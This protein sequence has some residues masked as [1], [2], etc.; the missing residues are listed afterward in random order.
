MAQLLLNIHLRS[1]SRGSSPERRWQLSISSSR[2]AALRARLLL[3]IRK[4]TESSTN[5]KS[6]RRYNFAR[7]AAVP[8]QRIVTGR[9]YDA[10]FNPH[11]FMSAAGCQV[12]PVRDRIVPNADERSNSW[13][14][15]SKDS[16]Q[17]HRGGC[18]EFM[19]QNLRSHFGARTMTRAFPTAL[20]Q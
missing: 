14:R 1:G 16:A 6:A 17:I 13:T 4:A 3:Q 9:Q 11:R 10:R 19:Y 15:R 12:R 7:S 18:Q 8:R 2:T 5:S 20:F